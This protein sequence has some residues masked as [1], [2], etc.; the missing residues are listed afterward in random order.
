M[1]KLM[2]VDDSLFMRSVLRDLV[3]DA[4]HS[5]IAEAKNGREAIG[6]YEQYLPALVTMDIT[7][8]EM[9]G[10]TAMKI[11]LTI[12]PDAR[13]ITIS[14]MGQEEHMFEAIRAGAKGFV[15]KPFRVGE[16]L[17]EISYV[18]NL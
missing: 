11:L 15:V 12:H 16:V 8:P 13:I 9:D 17:Q 5:V 3:I 6:L 7:M 14:S 10:I 1:A 4:G 18:L 2:I